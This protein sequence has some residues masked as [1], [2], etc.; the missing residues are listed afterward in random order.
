MR[1]SVYDVDNPKKLKRNDLIGDVCVPLS[2]L[3]GWAEVGG[4]T[5]KELTRPTFAEPTAAAAD[6]STS[7]DSKM[8]K[9]KSTAAAAAVGTIH[10]TSSILRPDS[11]Y[12]SVV[13]GTPRAHSAS[14]A[15]G[16][17][18]GGGTP[19]RHQSH[20]GPPVTLM[21]SLH[22]RSLP[23]RV[24]SGGKSVRVVGSARYMRKFKPFGRTE[25]LAKTNDPLFS[26]PM[27]LDH[28]LNDDADLRL[29]VYSREPGK[30]A[31][32]LYVGEMVVSARNL[33][34]GLLGREQG[35]CSYEAMLSNA[36][37]DSLHKKLRKKKTAVLVT[38][39]VTPRTVGSSAHPRASA[40]PTFTSSPPP[41]TTTTGAAAAGVG[42]AGATTTPTAV[43]RQTLPLRTDTPENDGVSRGLFASL[44][45]SSSTS[46]LSATAASS[47]SAAAAAAVFASDGVEGYL[48]KRADGKKQWMK[49]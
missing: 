32:E 34:M 19:L 42:A 24:I 35:T 41:S 49:R 27:T 31:A 18:N 17:C 6:Q 45:P 16:F 3:L 9:N 37:D 2:V 29:A 12:S 22:C 4:T 20:N 47:G 8:K 23:E 26:Q 13:S 36:M 46:S 7:K 14:L 38:V 25:W 11:S 43:R 48:F 44:S 10:I 39:T 5:S 21:L 28:W 15:D 1:F 40:P 30:S 33:L